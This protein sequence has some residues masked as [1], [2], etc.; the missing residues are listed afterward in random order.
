[1]VINDSKYMVV[2]FS[3]LNGILHTGLAKTCTMYLYAVSE[4][5]NIKYSTE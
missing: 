4:E 1:M 3:S 5:V 2:L